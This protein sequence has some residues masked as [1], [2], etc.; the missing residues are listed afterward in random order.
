M[1][2]RPTFASQLG[3]E[4]TVT[5]EGDHWHAVLTAADGTVH[6]ERTSAT[7]GGA[8]K[9][10]QHYLET[11]FPDQIAELRQRNGNAKASAT[12]RARNGTAVPRH[13]SSTP[14]MAEAERLLKLATLADAEADA[15]EAQIADLRGSAKAYRFA[16]QT[17]AE[18][19][20]VER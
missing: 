19:T 7:E 11:A 15:I 8:R 1:A 13:A 12:R 3:L 5:A 2:G 20:E 17:L 6:L 18:A 10:I 9:M 4:A 14:L 16:A